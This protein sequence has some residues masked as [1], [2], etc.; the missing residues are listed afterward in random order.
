MDGDSSPPAC[1]GIKGG[2]NVEK[3]L[4]TSLTTTTP[5]PCGAIKEG[6][7]APLTSCFALSFYSA[8]C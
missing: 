4:H 3:S 6:M 2:L 5:P 7:K 1:G 8:S